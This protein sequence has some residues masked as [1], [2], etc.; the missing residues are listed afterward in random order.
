MLWNPV[1]SL[2]C[3]LPQIRCKAL[4]DRLIMGGRRIT[5]EGDTVFLENF[6]PEVRRVMGELGKLVE[7]CEE[8]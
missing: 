4:D 2:G 8:N 1:S 3:R 7:N 5:V 6:D